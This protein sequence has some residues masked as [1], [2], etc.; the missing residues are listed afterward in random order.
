MIYTLIET[1]NCEAH[2]KMTNQQ[3]NG[4]KPY[5]I[6]NEQGQIQMLEGKL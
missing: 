5:K 3:Q 4:Q 2:I 6:I 1:E